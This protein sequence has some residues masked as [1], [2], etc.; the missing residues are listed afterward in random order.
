MVIADIEAAIVFG[1]IPNF[2]M[3][4]FKV[5]AIAYLTQKS[6]HPGSKPYGK[7]KKPFKLFIA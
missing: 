7:I 1:I 5:N 4:R 2:Y 3:L 6:F